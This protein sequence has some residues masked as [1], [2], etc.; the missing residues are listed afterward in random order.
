MSSY[1]KII[2]DKIDFLEFKQDILFLKQPQH[3][4]SVFQELT[5]DDFLKIRD[6]TKD[7]EDKIINGEI[8]DISKYEKELFMIWP[9][10]RSL[11]SSS[12]LIAKALMT[13][14]TFNSLFKNNN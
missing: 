11:P 4:A 8:Y 6:F 9:P 3:K 14:D 12:T 2:Y 10:V 13:E 1:V 7:I 5:L